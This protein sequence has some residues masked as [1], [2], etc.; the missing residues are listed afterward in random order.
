[1][2]YFTKFVS[3]GRLRMLVGERGITQLYTTH[4]QSKRLLS[5]MSKPKI[6]CTRADVPVEGLQILKNE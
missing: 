6:F 5:N 2:M 4:N 1:M 3:V